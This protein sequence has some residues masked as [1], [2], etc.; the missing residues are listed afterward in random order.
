MP[1]IQSIF[2]LNPLT[3]KIIIQSDQNDHFSHNHRAPYTMIQAVI[4]HQKTF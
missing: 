1:K 3:V 2:F 4:G